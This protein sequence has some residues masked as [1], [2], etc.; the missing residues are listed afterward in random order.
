MLGIP[1]RHEYTSPPDADNHDL[2]ETVIALHDLM[3]NAFDGPP[4]L[5]R[6]HDCGPGFE[7][8]EFASVDNGA[9]RREGTGGQ[10]NTPEQHN[11]G[12]VLETRHA[13]SWPPGP[14]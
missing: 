14:D 8:Q 2:I 3:R 12:G 1:L 6:I 9:D 10:K 11:T 13:L 5:V 7:S 4:D